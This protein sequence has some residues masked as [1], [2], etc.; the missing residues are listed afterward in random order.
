MPFL[1][2]VFLTIFIIMGLTEVSIPL[3]W[4]Y[5]IFSLVLG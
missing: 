4:I 1:F 2:A 3:L 5:Y